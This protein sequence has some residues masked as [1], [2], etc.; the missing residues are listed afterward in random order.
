M[1]EV[2]GV[3]AR[4]V[5]QKIMDHPEYSKI[6]ARDDDGEC[7]LPFSFATLVYSTEESLVT[8]GFEVGETCASLVCCVLW[9][10][11]PMSQHATRVPRA[12]LR[13]ATP[14]GLIAGMLRAG[15]HSAAAATVKVVYYYGGSSRRRAGRG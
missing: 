14:G 7:L 13:A 15:D 8:G 4:S 6:C 2:A 5:E 1:H 11:V 10:A 12:V 3:Q 9:R